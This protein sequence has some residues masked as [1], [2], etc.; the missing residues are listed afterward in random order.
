MPE[1]TY[2]WTLYQ[3]AHADYSPSLPLYLPLN[4]AGLTLEGHSGMVPELFKSL[5]IILSTLFFSSS[6][7][8]MSVSLYDTVGEQVICVFWSVFPTALCRS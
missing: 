1:Q 5:E 8:T 3:A 7:N 2:W 6:A 4:L